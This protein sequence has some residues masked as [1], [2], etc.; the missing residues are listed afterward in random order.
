[1]TFNAKLLGSAFALAMAVGSI[2]A[3]AMAAT[4]NHNYSY[5]NNARNC[6]IGETYNG[7]S[8]ANAPSRDHKGDTGQNN[9]CY[10]V[11]R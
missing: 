8:I 9:A 6:S 1:M 7:G 3:P 5:Q 10:N 11:G 2:A 4:Q